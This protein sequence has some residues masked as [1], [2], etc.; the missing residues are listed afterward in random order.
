MVDVETFLKRHEGTRFRHS[1]E[2]IECIK[3]GKCALQIKP[4][5]AGATVPASHLLRTYRRRANHLEQFDSLHAK[6]IREDVLVLCE[7]LE[8]TTEE[9]V[10]LWLFLMPP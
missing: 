1:E 6:T 9:S 8:Q 2:L 3:S 4:D 5:S 10:Q 7:N